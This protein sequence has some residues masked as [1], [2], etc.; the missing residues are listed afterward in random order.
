[1][2]CILML[3]LLNWQM[4]KRIIES[5]TITTGSVATK[6]LSIRAIRVHIKKIFPEHNFGLVAYYITF[7]DTN[8]SIE[9]IYAK[10]KW[11][12]YFSILTKHQFKVRFK[13]ACYANIILSCSILSHL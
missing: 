1:M 10:V 8:S 12:I 4:E 3:F 5:I 6:A 7:E 11:N 13:L 2:N 9:R